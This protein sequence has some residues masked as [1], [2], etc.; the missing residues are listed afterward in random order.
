MDNV[1]VTKSY[2]PGKAIKNQNSSDFAPTNQ[3]IWLSY[4][5]HNFVPSS[6]PWPSQNLVVE[7]LVK[8]SSK[9]KYSLL[10]THNETHYLTVRTVCSSERQSPLVSGR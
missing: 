3:S 9:E 6:N 2:I 1:L 5:V 8:V 10:D 7:L 4:H